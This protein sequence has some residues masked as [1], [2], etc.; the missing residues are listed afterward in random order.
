MAKGNFKVPYDEAGNMMKAVHRWA[1]PHEWRDNTPFLA[2]L[3]LDDWVDPRAVKFKDVDT[4]LYYP[5]FIT[6]FVQ[7]V[8]ESELSEG[9]T[10]KIYWMAVKKCKDYGIRMAES[11]EVQG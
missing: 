6:E 4:G 5:M 2:K 8:K 3:E 9:V 7:L 10:Y 11:Y 1:V